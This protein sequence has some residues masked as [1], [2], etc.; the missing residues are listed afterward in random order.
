MRKF[1]GLFCAAAMMLPVAVITASPAAAAAGP[2]C[3][4]AA[5]TAKFTPGLPPIGNSTK[6]K[7]KLTST[8]TVTKCTGVKGVT[9]GHTTFTQTSKSTGSNCTTLATPK[10]STPPTKG[11][12]TIKWSNGKT[13][14]APNT[15]I[16][17]VKATEANITGKITSGAFV[18]KTIKGTVTFKVP[19]DG[20]C[21]T[22]PLTKVTY[23]NKTGTKF[24]VK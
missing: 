11:T 17:Q 22:K 15:A 6:V 7:S 12:L 8:G 21:S 19:Q 13:S 9:G 10:P 2:T 1:L 14:K 5:G 20:S 23:T 3:A 24:T 18:G 4:K 16:K